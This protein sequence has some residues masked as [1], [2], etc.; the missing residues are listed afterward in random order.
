MKIGLVG[1]TYQETSLP[2][3]A[4]RSVNLFAVFDPQG[5]EVAAMYGTPGL[6]LFGVAGQGPGRQMF[7]AQNGRSFLI[8]GATLYELDAAGNATARGGLLQSQGNV[9]MAENGLQLAICD[10]QTLFIFTYATNAYAQV[11]DV[12]FPGAG[13]VTFLDGYFIVNKPNS[14]AFYISALY[15]GFSWNALDFAT[16]ESSPD[17]LVR[18][19]TTQGQL[20]LQGE[21]TTEIWTNT[22]DGTF[23]FQRI[24]GARM[25]VG[26]AAAHTSIEISNA[27]YWVGKD[28]DGNGIVYRAR[29]F[30]PERISTSPIEYKLQAIGDLSSLRAFS[31]QKGGHV[32]LMITGGTLET[33][34]VFDLA[35]NLWHER[36]YLNQFGEYEQHLG[37]CGMYAFNKFLVADRRN[38]N[39]YVLDADV[40]SDNGEPLCRERIYTHLGDEDKRIRYNNLQIGFEVGVG[41]QNGQGSDPI[42]ML[43]LSKDGAKTWSDW[44]EALIGRAGKFQTEVTYRRLGISQQMTFCLRVTDPVPVRITGSYLK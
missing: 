5:K 24:S 38:G 27:L 35:T 36:A 26:S 16:A 17:N 43:R 22:G 23:P 8:S 9:S 21:T 39:I 3:D 28:K 33:T 20:F 1:P 12:D 25:S 42:S 19:Y 31:Y 7:A 41:I 10:G 32:F 29:G 30:T 4:Q 13:T 34:L 15:D 40:F 11:T 18:V 6:R 2:F 14:G 37:A 44:F